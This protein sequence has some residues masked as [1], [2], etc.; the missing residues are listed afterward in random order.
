MR[1][2][3]ATRSFALFAASA[4]A[5]MIA[6]GCGGGEGE[7]EGETTYTVEAST[8]MTAASPAISKPVFVKRMNKI[9][10]QAWII[11]VDNFAEHRSWQDPDESE[12]DGF[13]D[14]VRNSLMAGVVFHIFD[15]FRVLGAPPGE[16]QRIEA[17][18]GSFQAAAEMGQK[19]LWTAYSIEDVSSQ[20]SEYNRRAERY[21]LGDCLVDDAHLQPLET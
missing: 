15:D 16:E 13:A 7:G 18:I 19:E 17:M 5:L 10:R 21:G 11:I 6:A 8:T 20:F 3:G 9:C 2:R 14:A 12:R 4:T 1:D